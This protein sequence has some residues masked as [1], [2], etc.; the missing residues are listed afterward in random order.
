MQNLTLFIL[1]LAVAA[2]VRLGL[3]Y[4]VHLLLRRQAEAALLDEQQQALFR[5][6]KELY[7]WEGRE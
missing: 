1:I 6:Q 7:Q 5:R 4:G 2:V 3:A